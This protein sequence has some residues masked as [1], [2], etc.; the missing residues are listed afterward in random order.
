M[1]KIVVGEFN[2]S[3][4]PIM[5][6]VVNVVKNYA[7]WLNKKFGSSYV[8]TPASPGYQDQEEFP[9]L[10]Y[11]S[12][13]LL[14]RHPYRLGIAGID[15]AFIKHVNQIPFDIVHAHSPFSAGSIALNIARQRNIP[16]IA[17]FHS[18]FYDDF[19]VGFK[20]DFIAKQLTK[21]VVRF[22]NNVNEVWAV[23]ETT[24]ETL[25]S[26]GFQG[27]IKVIHNGTDFTLPENPDL[28]LQK[29]NSSLKLSPDELVF[30]FVGRHNWLKNV[31]IIIES[32]SLLKKKGL[33]FKMIFVGTGYAANE[34]KA[35]IKQLQL[36]DWVH[37]MGIIHDRDFLKALFLR[38]NLF[39]FPSVYDNAPIVVR[40][41]AATQC[42]SL[43]LENTNAAE[44]ILDNYNGFLAPNDIRQYADRILEV[45]SNREKM[46]QVGVMAQKTIYKNW[47]EVVDIVYENYLNII[48]Q[49][50][51]KNGCQNS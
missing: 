36:D 41:A 49:Y 45:S 20:S 23:N 31:H 39:L 11:Y 18:K 6:G 42:P 8:I 16:I 48:E 29:V 24:K 44:G 12:V 33:Q 40:E 28:E 4:P 19:K 21:R 43:L 32:L 25:Y 15:R 27:P 37:F 17:S 46:H 10:R 26:Y 9:V 2:D 13:P 34:M 5:D 1:K 38:A 14:T 22:F 47:E 35:R 50:Q 30:L 51:S 3:F 7:Y